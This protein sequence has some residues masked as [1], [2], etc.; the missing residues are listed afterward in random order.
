MIDISQFQGEIPR[1]SDKLLPDTNATSAI[2]CDLD[3]GN[4][5]PMGGVSSILDIGA[6]ATTIFKMSSSFLQWAANV[7]V[8]KALVANS[9]NRILFTG[10]GYPKETNETLALDS[11]PYPT[12]TRRLGIPAPTNAL[13]ITPIGTAGD[14]IEKSVSYAYTIVGKWADGSE[15]ESGPSPATAVFDWYEDITPRLTGFTDATATGVYTTHF[16]IYRVNTGNTGSEFQYVDEMEVATTTYDDTVTDDD[17]QEVIATT[18]WT[19]PDATLSGLTATSH[20]L[21]FGFVGNTIYPSEVFITYAFPSIYSLVVESDIVGF[22]YTGSLVVV[23]TETVPYLLTGQDPEAL[24]L[25]R[26]G[27]QQSCVSARSIVNI[28]GGVIYASPDGLFMIDESGVGDLITKDLF[29]KT[30]WNALTPAN[31]FGFYYDDSYIGFFSGTTVGFRL[32]LTSDE[33]SPLEYKTLSLTQNVY[34]GEYSSAADLLYLIQT[35]G[36]V[37]E[38]VSWESGAVVNYTWTSKEFS[39][40]SRDTFTAGMIIGD[41]TAGNVTLTFYA[42]GAQVDSKEITSNDLFRISGMT[43]ETF[44]VKAVGKTTIDRLIIGRSVMEVISV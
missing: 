36:A 6:T 25:Q 17:L 7:N 42:D 9:G 1:I 4:L 19:S 23:L 8:V 44:Q 26:L 16:R 2:N 12:T 32:K 22:G 34:G 37:R 39:F 29:T 40:S 5:K 38:I 18:Y 14:D 13:T 24:S 41:F 10:D 35:K 27:Y 30:Q 11:S 20:G 43:G 33:E 3:S 28:P 15:V 31:L 21:V